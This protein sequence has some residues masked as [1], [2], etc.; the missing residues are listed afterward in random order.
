M[1]MEVILLKDV[2]RVGR[3][4]EVR[5]VAPGYARNY[6]I[7]Q[8]LAT[9]ATTGA[10][11]QVELQRQAGAR[12]EREL[13]DEARK[14]A[15][16]LEGVTLTLPAKTGEKDRLYGSI[17]SGD[18]ADALEREIGRSVDRRKLDLEEPIRELGTYSVPFKLLAD[19]A[20]TIT[21]D[22]VRQEDLG[23]EREGG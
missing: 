14:F 10:L 1:V 8:G 17:T 13:E 9:L 15:A 18:I 2:E 12:R 16:E 23:D 3:A 20:P 19:L 5:D 4:G 11:K 22:V 7:P 21:V 6:L